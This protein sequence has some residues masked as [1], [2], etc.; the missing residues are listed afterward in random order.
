MIA[1]AVIGLQYIAT[2]VSRPLAG[3]IADTHG[4]KRAVLYGLGVLGIGGAWC[5]F[6]PASN[7]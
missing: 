3:H 6:P 1:G 2:L 5:W 7:R 4:A